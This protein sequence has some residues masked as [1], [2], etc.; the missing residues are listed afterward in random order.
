MTT[1][2]VYKWS[3]FQKLASKKIYFKKAQNVLIKSE[4]FFLLLF[5]NV[6]KKKKKG[7]NKSDTLILILDPILA[8]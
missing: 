1:E 6:C 4:N 7:L 3:K 5:Y 8:G 2:K